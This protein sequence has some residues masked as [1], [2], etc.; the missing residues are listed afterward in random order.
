MLQVLAAVAN[1]ATSGLCSPLPRAKIGRLLDSDSDALTFQLFFK[2]GTG[3]A[4]SD[5]VS[6]PLFLPRDVALRLP[7][8][9][10]KRTSSLTFIHHGVVN[11]FRP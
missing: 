11:G 3:V 4:G 7:W 2:V 10:A 8:R 5:P 6:S 9:V 1:S